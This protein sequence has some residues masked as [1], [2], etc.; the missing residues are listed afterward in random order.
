MRDAPE[1]R[2]SDLTLEGQ[3]KRVNFDPAEM[4]AHDRP[5]R[6]PADDGDQRSGPAV[7]PDPDI[8]AQPAAG[9][10]GAIV[11]TTLGRVR[12]LLVDKVQT[13]KSVPYGASTA[14]ARRFLSPL[15]AAS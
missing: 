14:G 9:S 6:V 4:L 15:K 7:R 3:V 13:F 8:F 5:A 11:D 12:G 2:G 10:P 1:S